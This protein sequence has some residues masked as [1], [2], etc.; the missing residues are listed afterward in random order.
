M[1]MPYVFSTLTLIICTYIVNSVALT[2]IPSQSMLWHLEGERFELKCRLTGPSPTND[3]KLL[4]DNGDIFTGTLSS[5]TNADGTVTTTLLYEKSKAEL[6][7]AGTYKCTNNNEERDM[8]VGVVAVTPQHGTFNPDQVTLGCEI[9][10]AESKDYSVIW[11]K[12]N[13]SLTDD[14]KYSISNTS[15]SLSILKP[16]NK[17]GGEYTCNFIFNHGQRNLSVPVNFYAKPHAEMKEKK[18][19]NL[20]QDSTLILRCTTYGHPAPNV[21]WF[22]GDLELEPEKDTRIS[23]NG[24]YPN[25]ELHI[26]ELD[27]DDRGDYI[28]EASSGHFPNSTMRATILIRIKDKL[29]ALWPFLATVAEVIILCI[30][31]FICEKRKSKE[32]ED[33]ADGATDNAANAQDHKGKDEVRQRNV[34][35]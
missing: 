34:R 7:D 31:I 8:E 9:V 4:K 15:L 16:E 6:S 35:A 33:D 3:L 19:K 29:A 26:V 22:K 28:C 20:A 24:Q 18:S 11:M 21:T 17:D 10:G 1:N 23:I 30:I 14:A 5:K 27:F 13:V 2:M 32:V 25:S 12:K